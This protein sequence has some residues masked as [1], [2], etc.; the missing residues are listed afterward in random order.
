MRPV[1][2]QD[3][4]GKPASKNNYSDVLSLGTVTHL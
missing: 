3:K 4:G 2:E 1:T